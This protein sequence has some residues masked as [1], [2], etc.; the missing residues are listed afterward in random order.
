[1]GAI[2]SDFICDRY[3][4]ARGAATEDLDIAVSVADEAEFIRLKENLI[5]K[6]FEATPKAIELRFEGQRVDI[7]PFGGIANSQQKVK[8]SADSNRP[9]NVLGF[10]EA[11]SRSELVEIIAGLSVRVPTPEDFILLKFI[12]YRHRKKSKDIRDI[13]LLL[14]QKK[15]ICPSIESEAYIP[16]SDLP[17]NLAALDFA[18]YLYFKF[19]QNLAKHWGVDLTQDICAYLAK[20]MKSNSST[21]RSNIRAEGEYALRQFRLLV[22]GIENEPIDSSMIEDE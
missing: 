20:E 4:I 7:V 16:F 21:L 18:D 13:F 6:G 11:L 15:K 14:Q 17:E 5:A 8:L 10:K 2:A 12:C 19:G 22:A 9:L 1:V 3:S